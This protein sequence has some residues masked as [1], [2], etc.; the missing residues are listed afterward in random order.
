MRTLGFQDVVVYPTQAL[1]RP[2]W[3]LFRGGPD[4]PRFWLQRDARH[5]RYTLRLPLDVRPRRAPI[6]DVP[7][8]AK[9][10]WCGPVVQHFGHAI[11]NFGSRIAAA[12]LFP[13]DR[14]LVFSAR[15]GEAP[16]DFFWQ[17]MAHFGVQP[18]RVRIVST[19]TR[20]A[21]LLVTAQAELLYGASPDAGHLD[22]LD[23]LA[24]APRPDGRRLYVSRAQL[25]KGKIA[26]DA[27]LEAALLRTG[28]TPFH[29]ETMPVEAQLAAYR[30][31]SH[32]IFAEGSALHGLE[33]LGRLSADVVVIA[34]R[35]GSRLAERAI[36][37]RVPT[38]TYIDAVVGAVSGLD[39]HGRPQTSPGMTVLDDDR[40]VASLERAGVA[41]AA[42]WS[43]QGFAN[44]RDADLA[45]WLEAR[46]A[47]PLHP[48]EERVAR[49]AIRALG[50]TIG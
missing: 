19:A 44:Q 21:S 46:L 20:F 22:L 35:R 37:A 7:V 31:A 18:D 49:R 15:P 26:G 43:R 33:L 12:S 9:G 27:Y 23:R 30:G 6:G 32:L 47:H 42:H 40:L 8:E 48:G 25:W 34:R 11:T 5:C 24:G 39:R 16:P 17:I 36:R 50:L 1:L 28:W 4:W 10:V 2:P 14:P 13:H 3:M 45:R 29:P 38:L 41:I